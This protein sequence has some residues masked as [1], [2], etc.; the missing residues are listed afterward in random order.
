MKIDDRLLEYAI[1]NLYA[2][3]NV[4]PDAGGCLD[5]PS[6]QQEWVQYRLRRS[7]LEQGLDLLVNKGYLAQ[8]RIGTELVYRLTMRGYEVATSGGPRSLMDRWR[9]FRNVALL[10]RLQA[11]PAPSLETLPA[12]RRRD[13]LLVGATA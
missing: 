5:L 4:Q 3:S 2:H 7:D 8:D 1:L 13:D 10:S 11:R 12:K 9:E 6:L